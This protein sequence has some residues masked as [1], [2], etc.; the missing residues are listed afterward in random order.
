MGITDFI[1]AKT[2]ITFDLPSLAS[3]IDTR[4]MVA[5][6]M[7]IVAKCDDGISPDETARMVELLRSRFQLKP[8]EALSLITRAVDELA[9]DTHLDEIMADIDN[10]LPLA[11]KEDVIL[12]VLHVIAADNVKD[13]REM[14]LLS[15]LIDGLGIPE[16]VMDDAYARYF[17]ETKEWG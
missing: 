3:N 12:M 10:E 16:E 5:T 4:S 9:R 15:T 6:L 1:Y 14:K 17:A 13:A 8:N 11:H 2:G 7:A